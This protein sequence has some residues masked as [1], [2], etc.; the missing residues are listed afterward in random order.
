M[1]VVTTRADALMA[2]RFAPFASFPAAPRVGSTTPACPELFSMARRT[3]CT[4]NR[5]I[6]RSLQP[7][8]LCHGVPLQ[9]ARDAGNDSTCLADISEEALK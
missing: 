2:L 3:S 4:H 7:D 8:K 1:W 5:L 6:R 9:V